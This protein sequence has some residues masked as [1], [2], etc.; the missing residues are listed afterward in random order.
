MSE[1]KNTCDC[2]C[3]IRRDYEILLRRMKILADARD[4]GDTMDFVYGCA[5]A[6]L[7]EIGIK[8]DLYEVKE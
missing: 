5:N 4:N 3:K 6:A 1:D 8:T 2:T 7:E